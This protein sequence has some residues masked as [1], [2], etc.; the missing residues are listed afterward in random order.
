VGPADGTVR[1]AAAVR[2]VAG[3]A[4]VSAGVLLLGALWVSQREAPPAAVPGDVIRV[5]VVSGQSV[6][7]YLAQSRAELTALTDP[8]APA[9]GD[10]WALVS[11]DTYLSPWRLPAVLQGAPAAQ[12]Y[13]RVP[14]AGAQTS[15]VRIPVYG[16]PSDLLAGMLT[17]AAQR[18]QE[19]AEY[20]QLSRRL[21]D[22]V[23][24]DRARQAYESSAAT[25]AAEAAAYRAGCSCVFGA[26][27]HAAPAVLREIAERPGVRAVDPAPEVRSLDRTEF[28]PPL[29]E[30]DGTV[31]DEPNASPIPVPTG[32]S[33]I[34]SHTPTPILSSSGLAV[35]STSAASS[36]PQ[37]DPSAP[38][39]EERTAVPSATDASAAQETPSS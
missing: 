19:R 22:D 36:D 11:M 21:G 6:G 30:Q 26:V 14:L 32:V 29:P 28:C 34:A 38:A 33:A 18:E 15:V 39:S 37:P 31:P 27:V 20:Q 3:I 7:V 10:T 2:V 5:G 13:T 16:L 35:T 8:S 17:A 1:V 4:V 9:A 25:A 23:S 12:V 24:Q